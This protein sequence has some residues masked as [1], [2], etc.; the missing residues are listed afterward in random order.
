MNRNLSSKARTALSL[1]AGLVAGVLWSG[2]ALAMKPASEQ[3]A[4]HL[5]VVNGDVGY[6]V[7]L[8]P[9]T[10]VA[11]PTRDIAS[12]EAAARK[13]EDQAGKAAAV[14]IASIPLYP[15]LLVIGRADGQAALVPFVGAYATYRHSRDAA[16]LREQI[17]QAR[18]GATCGDM[19]LASAPGLAER[20]PEALASDALL[21]DLQ[22]RV[23]SATQSRA[24]TASPVTAARGENSIP[25]EPAL[26][27]AAEQH[28]PHLLEVDV[29]E[30][31]ITVESPA[32]RPTDCRIR[33]TTSADIRVWNVAERRVAFHDHRTGADAELTVSGEELPSILEQPRALRARLVNIYGDLIADTVGS[34]KLE[35]M[36]AE[37]K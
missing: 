19:L 36:A 17:E 7:F 20:L 27:R 29:S 18:R 13:K 5:Y 14:T 32:E 15:L 22:G 33:V 4:E 11:D 34:P 8:P 35:F 1:A 21:Q 25:A 10:S 3:V 6:V 26:D 28:L 12:M 23:E 16:T 37:I 24:R 9:A 31:R 2:A 30:I